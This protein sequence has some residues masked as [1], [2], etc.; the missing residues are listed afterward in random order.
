MFSSVLLIVVGMLLITCG[1][2][3][4]SQLPKPYD[5]LVAWGAPVGLVMTLAGITRLIIPNFFA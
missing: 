3:G 1:F 4:S 5:A 2:W